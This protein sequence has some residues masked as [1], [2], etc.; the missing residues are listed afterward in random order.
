[1]SDIKRFNSQ[2]PCPICGGH[3]GLPRGQGVRCYGYRLADGNVVCTNDQHSRDRTV[4]KE[5]PESGGWLHRP[6]NVEAKPKLSTNGQQRKKIAAVYDYKD[7]KGVLRY[8]QVRFELLDEAGNP[9]IDPATGKRRK[10]F[11]LR[12]PDG[13][14]GYIYNMKGVER[15]PYNLPELID[16]DHEATVYLCEGEKSV[17]ACR[18]KGLIASCNSEGAGKWRKELNQ[19]FRL[20]DVVIIPDNDDEGRKHA[21]QVARNLLDEALSVKVLSLPGLPPKGD[22]VEWFAAGGTAEELQR[23]AAKCPEWDPTEA[24]AEEI[25]IDV[26]EDE[27]SPDPW[28]KPL[29]DEAFHGIAGDFVKLV[30]PHTE[31][32]PAAVLLQF[33][34]AY[35]NCIGRHAHFR[36]EADTHY[37]NLFCALVGETSRGRKGTSWGYVRRLFKSVDV[38]W[39][40]ERVVSGLSSGEGLKTS[41]RDPLEDKDGT[42]KDS[43]VTDKRL[44]VQE[45]EFASVL[46]VMAREGNTLSATIRDAWDTGNLRVLTKNNPIKATDA[47]I[48]IL[49]HVTKGELLKRLNETEGSNGFANRFMW[50][51]VKRSKQLAFGGRLEEGALSPIVIQLESA[52]RFGREAKEIGMDDAATRMFEQVY[53]FLSREIPGMLGACTCRAE[54]QVRRLACIYALLDRK[55]IVETEHLSAALAVWEYCE[56]SARYVFG[57]S[58]GDPAADMILDALRR[59]KNGITRKQIYESVFQKNKPKKEIKAA[60]RILESAMLAHF[61][62][63][64][65]KGRPSERW[66]ASTSTC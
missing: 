23:L 18:E 16:A 22:A 46:R 32:D 30:A 55:D 38:D 44:L 52:I 65:T 59:S 31:A 26:D 7:A 50:A 14:G 33:L 35:G 27:E 15:L 13:K 60:L 40:S 37:M 24:E 42:L 34:T 64:Q 1:M 62:K 58:T 2:N 12:R 20:R 48:S 39:I 3:E 45:P 51:V 9:L 53:P 54:A 28:P 43:G 21:E 4:I 49:T 10:T 5:M 6:P 25:E 63:E 11:A 19:Y 36:V 56:D 66:F 41:V 47:H 29:K 57:E 8:Q 17:E 61:R